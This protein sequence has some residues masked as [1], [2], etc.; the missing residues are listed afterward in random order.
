M[1]KANILRKRFSKVKQSESKGTSYREHVVVDDKPFLR[2]RD[3]LVTLEISERNSLI[4]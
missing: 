1:V 2:K 3:H 4:F